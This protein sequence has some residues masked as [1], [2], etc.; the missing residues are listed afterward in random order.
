MLPTLV[1]ALVVVVAV[2]FV[3]RGRAGAGVQLPAPAV[4]VAA[5]SD[6]SAVA[7]LAGGCFWGVQAVFQHLDGVVSAVS[8]YA[9][10]DES[11]ATYDAVSSGRT[12]HAESVRITYDPRR[13]SYGQILQV[14]FSVA[15][16]PTQ[17]NR[18]GPDRGPQYRTTIFPENSEQADVARAYIAQ[19]DRVDVFDRPIVTTIEADRPFYRA[20]QYH[21]DFLERNPLNPYIVVHDLPKLK[22]LEKL[23]P[24][25]YRETPVLVG[26]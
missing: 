23:F 9:G 7:V 4:D 21:Q 26:G 17:L 11:S 16:D 15:H 1:L 19:L 2:G 8:G 14:F 25:R 13:V 5:G 12:G 22:E 3:L 20:E 18:Q 24:Q 10:G 6:T